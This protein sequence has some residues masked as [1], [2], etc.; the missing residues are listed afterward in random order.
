MNFPLLT[1]VI[2]TGHDV[3]AARQQARHAA[4][5]LG[6]DA[7]DQSRIATAVS[8]I[9]RNTQRYA[10]G[11]HVAFS[12]E[13]ADNRASLIVQV[14]DRGPGIA[15]V[16]SIL[17]GRFQ[18]QTGMGLGI[19]GAQRLMD[20]FGIE[21]TPG[22]GTSVSMGKDLPA[23]SP[24]LDSARLAAAREALSRLDSGDLISEL[25]SQN[26]ELMRNLDELRSRQREL[27]LLNAELEETNRGVVALY[28]ELD[29]RAEHLRRSDE[30]K[31]RFLSHVSHEFRTPLNSIL[32]LCKLLLSQADG[33]LTPEQEKQ[34]GYVRKSGESLYALVNDLLDLAKVEA[35]KA[36]VQLSEFD[37]ESFFGVLRGMLKPLLRNDRVALIFEDPR[38]VPRLRTDES[39]LA[40]ILR[41]LVSNALKFTETGEVRVSAAVEGTEPAVVFR[42]ADTGIG[43]APEHQEAIFEE[44][45]QV[46]NPLQRQ[47]KGTGLGLPLSR[48]LAELLG[49]A[50]RLESRVGTGS[51]FSLVLPLSRVAAGEK[52]INPSILII[53]DEEISRYLLRQTLSGGPFEIWESANG[54]EGIR[55]ARAARPAVI[56][57]DLI[58]EG[59]NGFEVLREL[60]AGP[61]TAHIPV[62]II[63]SK[64]LSPS[65]QTTAEADA[66][67]VLGKDILTRPDAA[68][69][70]RRVLADAIAERP[71]RCRTT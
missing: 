38:G 15:D 57:L 27:A 8:E 10:H 13:V 2:R 37:V 42:V 22:G 17:E 51:T 1:V 33:P 65:E 59:M 3:V 31:S 41:N 28:A 68:E 12:A 60:K 62:V 24:A 14:T 18:S 49:G 50:I 25:Q 6:F 29:E 64:R 16:A 36:N 9:A 63:T 40:Q 39:K 52:S 66:F 34:I 19:L 35:G 47:A 26:Q 45:V 23:A 5:L 43:I 70:I 69:G 46:D 53:D 54:P 56:L 32:A 20:S 58:M 61:D 48:E 7:Q 30:A 55:C 21:S 67:A 11:G 4:N 44:F 71:V